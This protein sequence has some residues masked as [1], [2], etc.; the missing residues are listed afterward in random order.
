MPIAHK[1]IFC[2]AGL[3][4]TCGSRMLENFVSPYDAHVVERLSAAGVD[5]CLL[6]PMP[7]PAIAYLTQ[8]L[9]AQAGIVISGSHNAYGDNGPVFMVWKKL[10]KVSL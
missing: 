1:D 9:R 8:T 7:T 4:T 3:R 5:I 6:G 10:L 2:T